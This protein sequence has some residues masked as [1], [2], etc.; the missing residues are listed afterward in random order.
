MKKYQKYF[1]ILLILSVLTVGI[2]MAIPD[3]TKIPEKA[4]KTIDDKFLDVAT[5]APGFGGMFVDGDILKIYLT[6]PTE[7]PAAVAAIA[8]VFGKER[9]KNIQVLQGKYSFAQLKKWQN[10][11]GELF[12]MQ[13]TIY[14]DVDEKENRI[15][16]GIDSSDFKAVEQRLVRLGIPRGA[17][18]IEKTDPIVYT[19]SLR[20]RIRPIQ[21]G[22][23]IAYSMY[24]CTEGFNGAIYGIPG[25]VTASHCTNKKGG[26]E[27]T[28]HYQNYVASGNLIG[29]EMLDP[30][31]TKVICQA[32]G[33][34]NGK[35]RYSDSEFSKLVQGVTQDLGYIAKTVGPNTGSLIIDEN[36]KFRIT[37]EGSSAIGDQVSKVGR[38]TGWTKGVVTGACM[39]VAIAGTILICQDKAGA[40]VNGG[41]SGSAVFSITNSPQQNDIE[42]RGIL[43]GGNTAGTYFIYSPMT[44]IESDLGPIDTG[45]P[46]P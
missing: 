34:R 21:G 11:A 40:T 9:A 23:Q 16:I 14:T 20:D 28:Q 8:S 42:L 37:G 13:E 25:F 4:E 30:Y 15:K 24:V 43:W 39:N 26:V 10:R 27:N 31:Y 19:S 7:K 22:L 32:N 33:I 6:N 5:K 46:A 44:G 2:A 17:V 1:G 12:D 3:G 45:V 35:C 38:T 18:I 29:I 36:S 41:D